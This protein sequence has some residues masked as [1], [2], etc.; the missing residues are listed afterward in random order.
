MTASLLQSVSLDLPADELQVRIR[1]LVMAVGSAARDAAAPEAAAG[2]LELAA[3]EMAQNA[4]SHAQASHV[5]VGLMTA[6]GSATLTVAYGGVEFDPWRDAPPPP[7]G[8]IEDRQIGGLGLHLVRTL[9]D[10]V[11]YERDGGMNRLVMTKQ[12]A[13]S[14]EGKS[15]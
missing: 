10:R 14:D 15:E 4:I 6:P 3:G 1:T 9:M 11:A 2:H 13:V 5:D 12:W 8:G 7:E